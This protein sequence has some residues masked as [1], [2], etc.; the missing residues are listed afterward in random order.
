MKRCDACAV[1]IAGHWSACPL[2]GAETK[3]PVEPSPFPTV[4]L[5]FSRKKILRLLFFGS[6]GLILASLAV[7][8]LLGRGPAEFGAVRS[9][10]LGVVT[11]WLVVLI[12]VRK[13]RNVAKGIVYLVLLV[14][15]LCVYW[16]YLTGWHGWS[17][18]YAVPIVCGS[19]VLALLITVW[20]MRMEVGN[21]IIYSGITILLGLLPIVFLVFGWVT[22]TVP[23]AICVAVSLIGLVVLQ[24]YRGA[25]VR[26]ELAKRLHV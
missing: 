18:N 23:S 4:A 16:D 19:S 20:S 8:L 11:M 1:E 26:H 17:L 9:V 25:E 2:C 6:L 7:Q 21:Y 24:V 10:W 12:A 5:Q 14:G 3:G 13:R 22:T 15:L